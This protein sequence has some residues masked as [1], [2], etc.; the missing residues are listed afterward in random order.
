MWRIFEAPG[1]GGV[2]PCRRRVSV[3]LCNCLI[4]LWQIANWF[5]IVWSWDCAARCILNAVVTGDSTEIKTMIREVFSFREVGCYQF[6]LIICS[7][8]LFNGISGKEDKME[9]CLFHKWSVTLEGSKSSW[10][11]PGDKFISTTL[12]TGF[13]FFLSSLKH[14][15]LTAPLMSPGVF[16]RSLPLFSSDFYFGLDKK[17]NSENPHQC[18]RTRQPV[19]VEVVN[20]WMLTGWLTE[21]RT[22]WMAVCWL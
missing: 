2:G 10:N 8:P 22:G 3:R 11:V 4:A 14:L 20:D 15:N 16:V 21:C 9:V 5:A 6:F 18:W 7:Q 1:N 12:L 19:R 17:I 13:L